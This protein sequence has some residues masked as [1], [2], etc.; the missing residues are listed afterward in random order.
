MNTEEILMLTVRD[1]DEAQQRIEELTEQH[2]AVR[3]LCQEVL[4]HS[5]AYMSGHRLA[6]IV[7][8]LIGE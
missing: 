5:G 7:L 1:L 3:D 6:K 4:R 8:K 2:K